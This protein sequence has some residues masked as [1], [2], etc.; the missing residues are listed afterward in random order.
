MKVRPEAGDRAIL[1]PHPIVFTYHATSLVYP[2]A[3]SRLSS[4]SHCEVLLYILA[5]QQYACHNWDNLVTLAAWDSLRRSAES[6]SGTTYEEWFRQHTREAHGR[7]FVTE[8]AG[9]VPGLSRLMQASGHARIPYWG[10][11]LTRLRAVVEPADMDRDVELWPAP[12]RGGVSRDV[13]LMTLRDH[14]P[15]ATAGV[16]GMAVLFLLAAPRRHRSKVL[17]ALGVAVLL[18]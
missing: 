14:A 4:D 6:P 18:L 17:A 9:P 16:G 10:Y 12:G 15:L 8:F 7:L 1:A 2:M 11:Y 5:P 13:R 3:I